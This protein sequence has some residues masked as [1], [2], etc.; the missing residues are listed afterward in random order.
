[1][2]AIGNTIQRLEGNYNS[3]FVRIGN[4]AETLIYTLSSSLESGIM[5]CMK[6]FRFIPAAAAAQLASEEVGIIPFGSSCL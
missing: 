3:R 6:F 2:D 4:R 5:T 1:M